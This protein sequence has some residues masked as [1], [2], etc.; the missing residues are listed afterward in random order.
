MTA[1]HKRTLSLLTGGYLIGAITYYLL[2][3]LIV[4]NL[5]SRNA[6]PAVIGLMAAS[7]P[8]G[9]VLSLPA[10]AWLL[11]YYHARTLFLASYVLLLLGALGFVLTTALPLWAVAGV[12]S[13]FA[14]GAG[15]VIAESW[16]AVLAPNHRR[17]Q[18]V[19][20][21]EA[22]IGAA[23]LL[24]PVLLLVVGTVGTLP[25]LVAAV[26]AGL[27]LLCM[28]RLQPPADTHG[29][30][31]ERVSLVGIAQ[32]VLLLG[33]PVLV[34][35]LLSGL[36]EAGSP[37]VLPPFSV[38]VGFS[39]TQATLLVMVIGVGSFLQVLIGYLADRIPW[40]RMVAGAVVV[41]VLVAL[42]TPLAVLLPALLWGVG[43]VWG[44]LGGGLYTLAM[45]R[46]SAMLRG[47]QLVYG[48]TT[49]Y[50]AYII[51]G[52]AGSTLG[53][54]G[55]SLSPQAGVALVFGGLGLAGMGIIAV[56]QARR[57]QQALQP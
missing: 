37:A 24:A 27:A 39:I 4:L 31:G 15:Y 26:L 22:S 7:Q 10:V 49:I 45:I 51:G 28:L 20:M 17:G 29:P 32:T 16:I 41:P 52:I 56:A 3:A 14:S 33:V 12:F 57:R 53:G 6:D 25:F 1:Y 50:F 43:L 2:A 18:I 35:S 5:T 42:L 47:M 30:S 9:L 46:V 44:L 13:G 55:L 40:Q 36:Y 54:A 11:Q 8:L 38:A 23:A 34:V 19:S 21:F 48:T